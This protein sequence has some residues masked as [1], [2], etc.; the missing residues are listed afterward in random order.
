MYLAFLL[1]IIM[2]LSV[3]C[4]LQLVLTK[5][6]GWY[7]NES[8]S[9]FSSPYTVTLQLGLRR[10][11][12][13]EMISKTTHQGPNPRPPRTIPPAWILCRL[14]SPQSRLRPLPAFSRASGLRHCGLGTITSVCDRSTSKL[15]FAPLFSKYCEG[16][17]RARSGSWFWV[18]KS[19]A[20]A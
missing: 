2:Y 14:H 6:E 7:Q 20:S 4:S 8:L 16:A 3:C 17:F 13:T 15:L 18:S 5:F 19:V 1:I 9:V 11:T 10:R 12:T